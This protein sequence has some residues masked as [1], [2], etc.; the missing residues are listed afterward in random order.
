[1]TVR[2]KIIME[3]G[4]AR[5]GCCGCIAYGPEEKASFPEQQDRIQKVGKILRALQERYGDR[6]DVSIVDPRN[7]I[8]FWD[9]IRY[10]VRPAIPVWIL[11]RKKIFEGVPG[12]EELQSVIDA[13]LEHDS[14]ARAGDVP[15]HSG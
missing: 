2:L 13:E 5:L 12:L 8:A 15:V 9:N 14:F 11:K 6:V 10:R 7:I 3:R 1:M 4:V